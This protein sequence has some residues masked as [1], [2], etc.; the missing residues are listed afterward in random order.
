VTAGHEDFVGY[1]IIIDHVTPLAA[2]YPVALSPAVD[3]FDLYHRIALNAY[4]SGASRASFEAEQIEL[5][6][7]LIYG[8]EMRDP[9]RRLYR[10]RSRLAWFDLVA[11]APEAHLD[12]YQVRYVALP[13]NTPRPQAL[14]SGWSLLQDGPSW[15]VWQRPSAATALE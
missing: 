9:V 7:H 13:A 1:A 4:V 12:A 6:N 5:L 8:V 11:S 2:D 14:D 10:L 15:K 3:D